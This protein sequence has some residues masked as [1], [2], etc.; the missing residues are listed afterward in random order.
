MLYSDVK[1]PLSRQSHAL[2]QHK[3]VR[4]ALAQE[5]FICGPIVSYDHCIFF[6]QAQYPGLLGSFTEFIAGASGKRLAVFLDYDGTLT[7]IVKNPDKAYMS[8]QVRM[9]ACAYQLPSCMSLTK[10]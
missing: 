5:S 4:S 9:Q 2:H 7:P 1:H 8:D 10:C 3:H 6:V